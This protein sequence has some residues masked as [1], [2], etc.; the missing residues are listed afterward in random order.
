MNVRQTGLPS[1]QMKYALMVGK[2]KRI[3]DLVSLISLLH[4][5]AVKKKNSSPG[6]MHLGWVVEKPVNANP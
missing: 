3:I 6:F 2:Q 4:V 1:L 5:H